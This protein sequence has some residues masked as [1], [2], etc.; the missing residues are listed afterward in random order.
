MI[1]GSIDNVLL[2][3]NLKLVG[4][5][6][7][8]VDK[9]PLCIARGE[10][11]IFEAVSTFDYEKQLSLLDKYSIFYCVTRSTGIAAKNCYQL[12]E[13]LIFGKFSGLADTLLDKGKLSR[14]CAENGILHP[15]TQVVNEIGQMA[16]FDP[17]FIVKPVYEKVGKIT[18]FKISSADNIHFLIDRSNDNSYVHQSIIQEY[19]EG[20]DYSLLGYVHNQ[21][22]IKAGLYNEKNTMFKGKIKHEG[23]CL[24]NVISIEPFMDIASKLANM[25]TIPLCPLNIGFRVL[26][27]RIFL[28]ECNLDFGGE[29]TLENLHRDCELD[30]VGSFFAKLK[31]I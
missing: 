31:N 1:G 17:P 10:C 14:F 4:F 3:T 8:V 29:G 11:D 22:Y 27:D 23:F 13:V 24:N 21:K 7:I 6:V 28:L 18:T 9:N 26:E 16:P 2:V 19:L 25:I 15:V 30:V 12:N 5:K 20:H